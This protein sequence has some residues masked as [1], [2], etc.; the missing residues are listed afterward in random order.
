MRS[1]L[2]AFWVFPRVPGFDPWP[3]DADSK[4][5]VFSDGEGR[6]MLTPFE[7]GSRCR[8][9]NRSYQISIDSIDVNRW[10][11]TIMFVLTTRFARK[12]IKEPRVCKWDIKVGKGRDGTFWP[13][14]VLL[15]VHSRSGEIHSNTIVHCKIPTAAAAPKPRSEESKCKTKSCST[16]TPIPRC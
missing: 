8:P 9:F 15:L 7:G 10:S 3:Y 1:I 2:W 12:W 13:L 14:A 11:N 6:H 5:F 16:S 4:C